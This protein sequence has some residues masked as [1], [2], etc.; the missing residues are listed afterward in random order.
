[1]PD[2]PACV[3]R[4]ALFAAI[5]GTGLAAALA[6]CGTDTPH[7]PPNASN[8]NDPGR[9]GESEREDG[10]RSS[11]TE[12]TSNSPSSVPQVLTTTGAVPLGGGKVISGILIVQPTAGQF[13]AF[14]A[15]CP[16]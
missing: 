8:E 5:G 15:R 6:G 10:S 7:K 2:I 11:P 14:D 13:K 1:A 3:S 12:P 4:R 16:H 9:D